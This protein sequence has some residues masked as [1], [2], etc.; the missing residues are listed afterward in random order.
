MKRL[1]AVL[2]FAWLVAA[3]PAAASSTLP[4]FAIFTAEPTR[5]AQVYAYAAKPAAVARIE[6]VRQGVVVAEASEA[7]RTRLAGAGGQAP[8]TGRG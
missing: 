6:I 4:P 1:L 8:G 2:V 5:G 3:A 7:G